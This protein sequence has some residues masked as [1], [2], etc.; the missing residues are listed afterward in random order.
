FIG[1]FPIVSSLDA[2]NEKDLLNI[3][4][5]PKNALVKQYQKFFELEGV[6]LT[7]T[8]E[9]LSEIVKEAIRK[10]TGARGLRAILE[11]LMLDV[12]Y[13]LPSMDGVR[14]CVIEGRTVTKRERPL[15][16]ERKQAKKIA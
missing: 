14:E 2:L 3:L 8:D 6:E 10:K 13:E 1:R 16:I 4:V 5:K 11:D 12:M 7:F 15:L 9:A